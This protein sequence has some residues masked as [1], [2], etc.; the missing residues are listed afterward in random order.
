MN[1]RGQVTL[2]I[3]IAI[4]VVATALLAWFFWPR[5]SGFF[6]SEQAT[7]AFLASQVAPVQDAVYD[8]VELTAYNGFEI[9]GLQAGYYITNLNTLYFAGNDFVVVAFKDSAKQ[10]INK[11]PSSEQI[12]EQFSLYL[13][14]E[15]NDA[16]DSCLND[17]SG[18]K[19]KMDIEPGERTITSTIR[20][21]SIII[22]VDWPVK[23]SKQTMR[24]KV[25]Q[26][27][28]QKPVTLLIPL[29]NILQVTSTI[30]ECETKIDCNYEGIEWDKHT[31]NNPLILQHM[32]RDAI[33][34][35][36]NQIN[37]FIETI[38]YRPGE[39]PYKFYFGVDRS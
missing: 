27:I 23:I 37:F 17:F 22:N 28:N 10:R 33:S 6:M 7:S 36:E 12:K 21:D 1:K 35:N 5:I 39:L 30:V 19:R 25:E 2:F 16:I 9:L 24:A 3:I 26:Q 11:L 15:G 14:K 38:P 4:V 13:E 29:G 31:W 32:T 18:F 34:L 8:C 20:D